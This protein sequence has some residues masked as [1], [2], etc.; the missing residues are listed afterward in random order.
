MQEI[1][2][3]QRMSFQIRENFRQKEAK[4]GNRNYDL[5]VSY[6]A[7]RHA[8]RRVYYDFFTSRIGSKYL[9]FV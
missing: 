4:I 3:A 1:Q 6:L 5:S 9:S 8:Q 7:K 2:N